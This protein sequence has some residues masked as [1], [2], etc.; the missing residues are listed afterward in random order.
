[1][2]GRLLYIVGASGVGK[3]SVLNWVKAHLPKDAHVH[4]CKRAITR[5]ANAGAETHESL[6]TQ[7]FASALNHG[8]FAMH[9]Q[10][11]GLDYGIRNTIHDQLAM[12]TTVVV[13]GSRAYLPTL[14]QRFPSAEII[15]IVAN[16]QILRARLEARAREDAK[17]IDERLA[18]AAAFVVPSNLSIHQI[19]N[20]GAIEVAGQAL[21]NRITQPS[22]T[23]AL[24]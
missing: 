1:M 7:E 12:G 20:D 22:S 11:H 9:W 17:A 15:Q 16:P 10:A 3:D 24:G 18:R 6:T 2:R 8:E 21:L 14:Y 23:S 5:P 13:S 4:F 19:S